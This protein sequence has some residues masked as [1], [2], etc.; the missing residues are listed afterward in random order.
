MDR[1]EFR[2][3]LQQVADGWSRGDPRS[4]AEAFAEVAV[5]IEPPDRQRYVGR[6]ALYAFFHGEGSEPR[7]M[8]MTWHAIAFDPASQTGF[9][10][11]TFTR[12]GRQKHGCAV[13]AVRSGLIASWREY[14]YESDQAFEDFAG[15]SLVG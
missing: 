4:A 13:V 11:Y 7:P 9:G 12:P 6:E 15:G 5:Y 3:L 8:T 2:Q 10:E 14:Q 1:D